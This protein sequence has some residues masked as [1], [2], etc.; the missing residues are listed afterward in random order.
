MKTIK[1]I[2]N[3]IYELCKALMMTAVSLAIC[4]DIIDDGLEDLFFESC[5]T[6]AV[7]VAAIAVITI[8]C[9]AKTV[10]AIRAKKDGE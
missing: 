5:S 10:I 8:G 3:A 7:M 2:M 4:D 9:W 1:R 6:N